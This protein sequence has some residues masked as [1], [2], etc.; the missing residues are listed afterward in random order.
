MMASGAMTR[1]GDGQP[2]ETPKMILFAAQSG[3]PIA[4]LFIVILC[5]ICLIA[6]I[7]TALRT[8]F[9]HATYN[10]VIRGGAPYC[11]RCNRQVSYRREQCRSCGHVYVTYGPSPEEAERQQGARRKR[12]EAEWVKQQR[13]ERSKEAEARR[14]Q[15]A[16]ERRRARRAERDA[17]YLDRGVKPGPWAWYRVLPDWQQAILFGLFIAVPIGGLLFEAFRLFR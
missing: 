12:A 14:L 10:V 6:L 4:G 2:D 1:T 13:I 11:P 8:N 15:E 16:E 7:L 9:Y 3:D 17:Y 5:G